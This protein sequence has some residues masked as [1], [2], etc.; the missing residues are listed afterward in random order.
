[1]LGAAGAAAVARIG[2][3]VPELQVFSAPP[4]STRPGGPV[5]GEWQGLK[6]NGA[7]PVADADLEEVNKGFLSRSDV[8][9]IAQAHSLKLSQ[10]SKVAVHQVEGGGDLLAAAWELP[11]NQILVFWALDQPVDG[12]RSQARLF[13]VTDD[14]KATLVSLSVN[15]ALAHREDPTAPAGPPGVVQAAANGCSGCSWWNIFGTYSYTTCCAYDLKCVTLCCGPCVLS[16]NNP[17]LCLGCFAVWCP[18]CVYWA[19]NCC[20]SW[21]TRCRSCFHSG[22]GP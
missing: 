11:S 4:K 14:W 16:C 1:L 22:P 18:I 20:T 15:G 19:G 6:L 12:I 13:Q 2:G 8:T 7:S 3:L 21:C 5:S 17:Y 9:E 10:T